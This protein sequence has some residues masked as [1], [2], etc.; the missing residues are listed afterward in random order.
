MGVLN[1]WDIG[2]VALERRLGDLRH[3][4]ESESVEES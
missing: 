4:G 1:F 2:V 3:V